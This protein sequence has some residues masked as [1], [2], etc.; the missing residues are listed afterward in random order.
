MNE[1]INVNVKAYLG[2]DNIVYLNLEN[3]A[4][5]LGFTEKKNGTEY[6]MWRRVFLYLQEFNFRHKCRKRK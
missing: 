1:L 2:K 4:K 6:V 3:V 5:G